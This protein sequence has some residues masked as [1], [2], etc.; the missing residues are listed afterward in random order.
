MGEV[1]GAEQIYT[2]LINLILF[3]YCLSQKILFKY[4]LNPKSFIQ[5]REIFLNVI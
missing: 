1:T 5:Y 3:N 4:H 2:K